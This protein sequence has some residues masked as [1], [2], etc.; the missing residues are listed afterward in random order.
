MNIWNAIIQGIIQ[1][2]T[3]FLPVSSSGHLA[4]SQHIMGVTENNLF[5]S[6]MLHLGTL[7]AVVIVYYKTIARLFKALI[8]LFSDI[9]K[10]KFKWSTMDE[11]RNLLFMLVIGLLPLFLL[12]IPIPFSEGLNA[13]DLAGIWSENSGY[14]IIVGFSLLITSVLLTVGIVA[15][16]NTTRRYVVRKRKSGEYA[17]PTKSGRKRF[18][19]MDALF[20]GLAQV[21]AAIFPGISRSGSTLAMGELRGINKQKALDYTF[22][23]AIPSI[24]AAAVLELKDAI[25]T[26]AVANIEVAPVIVGIITSAAVGLFAILLFKWMLSKERMYIFAIYTAI[27]GVIIIIIGIVELSTGL[28]QFTGERLTFG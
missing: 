20:V 6:V 18:S 16:K 15:N 26:N 7:A 3:E 13:K 8:S 1:G 24:L 10:G 28:N 25:E 2:L 4:I 14:F 9:F 5:F 27:V 11:D 23:L 22:I 17:D 12:F 19:A 21:V